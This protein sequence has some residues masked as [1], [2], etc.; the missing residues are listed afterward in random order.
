MLCCSDRQFS[1]HL[2]AAVEFESPRLLRHET[3]RTSCFDFAAARNESVAIE[4]LYR[5]NGAFET[6]SDRQSLAS[7]QYFMNDMVEHLEPRL[8]RKESS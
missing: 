7:G 5:L 6:G 3:T 1:V 4:C 8:Y 2:A